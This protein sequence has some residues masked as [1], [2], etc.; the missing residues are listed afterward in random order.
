MRKKVNKSGP[1]K[2]SKCIKDD[3][4]YNNSIKI[5]ATNQEDAGELY[6][7]P[8]NKRRQ[9]SDNKTFTHFLTCTRTFDQGKGTG[10]GRG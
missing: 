6:L 1:I 10:G 4:D 8:T 3:D 2:L 5:Y 7:R 9:I